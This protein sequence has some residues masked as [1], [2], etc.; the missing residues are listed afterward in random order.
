MVRDNRP[1]MID[2]VLSENRCVWMSRAPDTLQWH[3]YKTADVKDKR[4]ALWLQQEKERTAYVES[5]KR[6]FIVL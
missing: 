6:K 4:V 3:E 5:K 1:R 2:L